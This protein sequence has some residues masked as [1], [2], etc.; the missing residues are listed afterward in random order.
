VLLSSHQMAD[1][2]ELCNRVA[3]VHHGSVVYEGTVESLRR[4][5]AGGYSVECTDPGR[6]LALACDLGL[7]GARIDGGRLELECDRDEVE[8]FVSGLVAA[9][10]GLHAL[11]PRQ[12]S[13]EQLFFQL[14]ERQVGAAAEPE[15]VSEPV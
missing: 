3:I 1:V 6:A 5:V 7:D 15:R 10:V 11:V 4:S 13:L 14:T 2:E 9:G 8:R 12:A